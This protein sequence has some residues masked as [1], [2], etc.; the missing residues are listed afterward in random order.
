[1]KGEALKALRRIGKGLL[2]G[3][4]MGAAVAVFTNYCFTD[5]I[6]R[7]EFVTYYMRY[8]WEYSDLSREKQEEFA[9]DEYGIHIIDIDN[10]SFQKLGT[11]WNWDRSYH[12]EMIRSLNMHFP[13]AIVFDILFQ[14]PEDDNQR[15]RFEKI[16]ERTKETDARSSLSPA[17]KRTILSA[18]NYD[19]Q[20]IDETKKAGDVF[21]GIV[22]SDENDY[23]KG[24]AVS[25]VE[26]KMSMAWHDSLNPSSAIIIPPAK[27]RM[28]RDNKPVIDGI[29]PSL[30]QAA[31]RIG[32]VDIVPNEDGVIR[33]V[34]LLYTFGNNEP[35][36]LPIS[37]RTVAS[38]FGTP[39]AEI[40]FEPGKYLDIGKPF[41]IFKDSAGRS[42][43]SYPNFT[44]EQVGAILKSADSI[45]SLG[46][47]KHLD[48]TSLTKIG[49]D[50]SGRI[51]V[52]M[53]AGTFPQ[54]AV[55]SF[56][57]ADMKKCLSLRT[58][59]SI[60]L[61]PGI[62]LRRGSEPEWVLHA[63]VGD[64]E[65][66]INRL[67]LQTLALLTKSSFDPLQKGQTKLLFYSLSVK[68]RD[69]MLISSIPVL[70][71]ETLRQLCRT[72]WRAIAEMARGTRMDFGAAVRIPLTP[73]NRHIV[74][75]FGPK[76]K[77]FPYF[78]YYDILKDRIQGA[79]EGKIFVVGS[80]VPALF[81]IKA[82]PHDRNFPAVEVHAS[83]MNSFLTNTFITRLSLW[84]NLFILLLVGIII[85]FVSFVVKPLWGAMLSLLVVFVYFLIAMAVF[86]GNHVWIEIARPIL[87]IVITFTGVMVFRYITE[88]KDRKFLQ[89]TFKQ[90]LS[91]EL[92]DMMYNSKRQPKLGGDEGV[93]TAYFTDI[94]GFSTVSEKLGSP[95]RLVELLNE[96]LTVMT[97]S[98]LSHYGTLDKYEGDAII[99]FFGAPM[100]MD[101]H[102]RQACLTALD[103]QNRLGDL[104]KKWM[105]GG[106]KMARRSCMG[107]ACGSASTR[108]RS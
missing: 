83:L 45:L 81:D 53:Y 97:N 25:Q 105:C 104:R 96:Y 11:Y 92:I 23:Q 66:Y 38:L 48:V 40:D 102:A 101:D 62:A 108:A 27:R 19:R 59:D 28:I 50:A 37:V 15:K 30:A 21:H 7:L 76:G 87:A 8:K 78:S 65:W 70:R 79:L 58:A 1:M 52:D 88:E 82:A 34:P 91:P 69:G 95:T 64:K 73:D 36:Y 85:G 46:E 2:I 103:M 77:P 86:G 106:R 35:V 39:N 67:D 93:R 6:D 17:Q 84:E 4:V 74:T 44:I 61:G 13:A 71:G 54:E 98:L 90:Y 26:Q 57:A 10:R 99:A 94:E 12:A 29:F 14:N 43:C 3:S 31:K 68:N 32:H 16:L 42:T 47:G 63:P 33:E 9:A 20:F 5:L 60:V 24:L 41:K 75:Y 89:N 51:F 55:Q 72:P 107:C 56:L 49:R 18:I 100:P 22:L 80:T